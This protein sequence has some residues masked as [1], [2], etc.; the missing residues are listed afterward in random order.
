MSNYTKTTDFEAKDSLPTGD[1]G[2]IIKGTEFETEFDAIAV[3]IATK[4]DLAG[5]T[6]TGTATFATLSD[7]TINVT[8]FVDEDDMSSNSATL[9]PTQ[10]SVKAYVDSQVTAQD[11]DA[12]T[13]SGTIAIDLDS[14][15]LTVAGGEGIDTSATG[16]T[17]TI[18]GEDASTS[19]KGVASFSSDDFTVS[20]GAVS[21]ATTSTAAELNIL[22]GATVTTAE[23]NILDGVTSTAAELN[24]LDGVT[25]TAAELNIL[26]GVTSTTAELNILDGVTSTAAEINL[27]DGSSAGTVVNSKAVIYGSSGEVNATTLQVGG[28]AITSTPA[29]LNILDGVTATTAELNILDGV[30]STAAELNILDGK[31]FL[32]EDD[33]SS[34]S[35]T[36]IAS[37]QSIKAYVDAQVATADTLAEVLANGNTSGGTDIS[38]STGDDITFADSSKAI[39]GA[40]S[41]LQIYSDGSYSYLQE[42]SGTSGIRIT[43]DNQVAIR[44]HDDEDIAVFNIDG[45]VRFYHDNA[46]KFS[47]TSSGI[48]VTGSITADGLTVDITDQVIVNHSGD[49]GGIRIDST[50]DTNTGSLRFG[51][52]AD[53]YIGAVEYN[54]S[55][56]VLSLYADNATRM[57]V[58]STGIDVTGSITGDGLTIDGGGARQYI[59]SG[60]L[61]LSDDYKL[62][63]GG[64]TNS[65]SGS[66]SSGNITID[67]ANDIILD[68]AGNDVIFKDAGT[69][70]GQITNDSGNMVIYNSGSQMLKGLSGG[71]N[72]QFVGSV[73]AADLMKVQNAAGS[74]AAEVDIVSGGTWRLRSNPTT[75]TNSYGFDIVK[76]SAGT[77]VKFSIDSNGSSTFSGSVTATGGAFVKASSGASATSGT[78]LTIE[79]DDNTELSILGGS[80]SVLAINFGHSGDN[81]EGKITFNTT[82]GSEDLQLVSSKEIT[83]DAAGDITLDA[84]GG[85]IL[86]KDDGTHWASLFTNGTHTY[87]QNMVNSGDIYLSGRDSGGTGVNALVLDMSEGGKATFSSGIT[88]G[89]STAGDW[90]LTLNTASGDNMKLSVADTASAGAADA[91][92]SVSDGDLLL[93]ANSVLVGTTN[94]DIGG[95]STGIRL[96]ESGKIFASIDETGFFDHPIYAD[97]RG[98]NN[99]GTVLALGMQGFFKAAIDVHGT[100]SDADDSAISFNTVSGNNTK[101]QRMRLTSGGNL[102]LGAAIGNST[103]IIEGSS[104][105]GQTNQPGTDLQLKGGAGGG[106]GGSNIKFYT[107]PGGSS[108]TS[109]S[110]A[111]QRMQIDNGGDVGIGTTSDP[112]A[113]LEVYDGDV[114]GAFVPSTL[115]TWRVMQVR[116]NIESATGTAAGIALGGD[117]GSDT[118]TAGIVG[119]SDNSTGGVCQLAFLVATGNNSTEA[120]RINSDGQLLVGT[121]SINPQAGS[122]NTGVQIGDGHVYAGKDGAGCLILNRHSSN[123]EIAEFRRD[124]NFLGYIGANTGADFYIASEDGTGVGWDA[125]SMFPTTSTGAGSDNAKDLGQSSFRWDDVYA[126]NSTINTSDR[127]EKQDIEELSDAE[128][129]VAAA[130][131][132]LLKKFRWKSAV[133]KKGDDAR[134][135]FGI[136]AQDLQ[137]AFEAEGLD[138]G[139]YGMFISSTWT[140]EETGEERTRMGVRYSELLAFIISA[141]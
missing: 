18:A 86:L 79:D 31:A 100:S 66:N 111:V 57:S 61:R 103:A 110:A 42:G 97:R 80:S 120:M 136:I 45:A 137:A 54:H 121:T 104:G 52:T 71:S 115:S 90:G 131:K 16:N 64:A 2:K 29:E 141:I 24:I 78:V 60:H 77:D 72:A 39:F 25:S 74:S 21:L 27:I 40:G 69:T 83:L 124:G 140:D 125:S 116:N 8:A 113:R 20:S 55:T 84:G 128:Q 6:F 30:T 95:S 114:S 11:L 37:Q 87:L 49:G 32:D 107:A 73:T 63:W 3:A 129:R 17:I 53:N 88:A 19:N 14:E 123:G 82:A 126:T 112:R 96:A 108:G 127:N 101:T 1:S 105:A 35:A 98:T 43:S 47:T 67:A 33:M 85:D 62:E 12:T 91:T 15:T 106:T 75:G 138:A 119:I 81:D 134:I 93:N 58:S 48:D 10:Q 28:V 130:C 41:D 46:Q 133:E 135:H 7:G 51:D 89:T 38:V 122:S 76:G 102:V 56:N 65:I 23:L 50:N 109:E 36:G 4:A 9:I 13:D 34:N 99:T 118:E 5:P 139:R 44:K 26:D 92:I 117:G 94:A 70:F 132:G 68:A 22:D 59:N